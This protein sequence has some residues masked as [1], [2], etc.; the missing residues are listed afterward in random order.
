MTLSKSVQHKFNAKRTELDGIKFASKKEAA[1]YSELLIRIKIGE[2]L[3]FLRQTPFHLPGGVKYVCDFTEFHS[4]GT[5]WFV[6]VKG[7]RTPTY[8]AKKKMVEA[9]YPIEIT[10]A[11]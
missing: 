7:M 8:K 9:L 1:Y 3:F 5:V 4:D 6:D 11:L 10:E 2:V